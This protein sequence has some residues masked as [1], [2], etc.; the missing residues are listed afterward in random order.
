MAVAMNLRRNENLG[1]IK[2]VSKNYELHV[3]IY[4]LTQMF[5]RDMFITVEHGLI[6]CN[7]NN[8]IFPNQYYKI[9]QT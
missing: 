5:Q 4:F 1:N 8:N 6:P 9:L 2:V 3:E 7:N